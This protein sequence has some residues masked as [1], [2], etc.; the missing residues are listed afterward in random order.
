LPLRIVILSVA[1]R[2]TLELSSE[3]SERICFLP[4]F[5]HATSENLAS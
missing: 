1:P 2:F 3:R 5:A 4:F